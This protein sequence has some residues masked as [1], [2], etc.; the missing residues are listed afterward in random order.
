MAYTTLVKLKKYMPS[1]HI[2][3][4]TDDHGT[5]EIVEEV[6]DE[7]IADAQTVIDAHMRGRYPDEIADVD[8]PEMIILIA[9]ALT[10]LN[11]YRRKLQLTMPESL[12]KDIKIKMQ[13][14][15]DIQSGK[16][17][18]FVSS[19]EPAVIVSNKD[20]D[21]KTYDSDFWDGYD[22]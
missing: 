4:L 17:T 7:A 14:L 15:K 20:S 16:I 8:L 19:D 1:E 18:P 3:Q 5:G 22:Y 2:K 9:T 11:L 6:V 12:S 10:A 21:S 13:M